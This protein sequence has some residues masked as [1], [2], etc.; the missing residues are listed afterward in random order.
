MKKRILLTAA[1]AMFVFNSCSE[2]E[3]QKESNLTSGT[4]II[5]ESDNIVG[6][7]GS[8]EESGYVKGA[9]IAS[10]AVVKVA[11][12]DVYILERFLFDNII[13]LNEDGTVAY[14]QDLGEGVN[15]YDIE[16]LS[17]SKAYVCGYG[18]SEL[19]IIDPSTG[20]KTGSID[21]SQYAYAEKDAEN[22]PIVNLPRASDM[23]LIED[24]LYV[25]VQR[26]ASD[27]T[28]MVGS[29]VLV[30]NTTT[31]EVSAV[32]TC[33]GKNLS[34]MTV[35]EKY[36]YVCNEGSAFA[37]GDGTVEKI[38][39][40]DNSITTLVSTT[41]NNGDIRAV[42]HYEGDSLFAICNVTY[43]T[44]SV[45]LYDFSAN[46]I[47]DTVPG[48]FMANGI[49]YDGVEKTLYISEMGGVDES[50]TPGVN[51]FG[52]VA[53]NPAT[54]GTRLIESTLPPTSIALLK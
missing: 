32:I 53:Y 43:G 50:Y 19:L 6:W 24:M 28:P 5:T 47:V 22:N 14:Q 30:I 12:E 45:V 21:L 3:E 27:W 46:T 11:G 16:V 9:A 49:V 17:S 29:Q 48:I 52:I 36:I 2:V 10:D 42:E 35:V 8:Y 23:V 34:S 37:T 41:V 7:V 38:N 33:E 44:A 31:D 20:L 51:P 39:T 13:K 54:K 26:L 18:V 15:P 25:G 1:V 4:P 40:V